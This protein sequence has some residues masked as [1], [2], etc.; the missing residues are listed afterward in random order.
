MLRAMRND[1]HD[2]TLDNANV[3]SNVIANINRDA[4]ERKGRNRNEKTAGKYKTKK[5]RREEEK[6]RKTRASF[7]TPVFKPSNGKQS[8]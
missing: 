4:S 1:R 5:R 2:V 6:E 7:I 8:V 3:I